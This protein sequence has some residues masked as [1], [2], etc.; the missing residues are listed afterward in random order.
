MFPTANDLL[1][2][3]INAVALGV[4]SAIGTY[5]ANKG[6]IQHLDKILKKLNS[7]P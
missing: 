6:F 2:S 1:N 7:E 3:M 5:L 4:G